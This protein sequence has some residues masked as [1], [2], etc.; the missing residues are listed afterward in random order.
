[1]CVDRSR[2]ARAQLDTKETWRGRRVARGRRT[3]HADTYK[4]RSLDRLR[5][6]MLLLLLLL[7]RL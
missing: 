2:C 1:M 5:L 6:R 4:H 7:Q 3:R